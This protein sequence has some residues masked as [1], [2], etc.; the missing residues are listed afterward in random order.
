MLMGA[1]GVFVELRDTLNFIWNAPAKNNAGVWSV[2]RDR[3][4]SF[5]MVIAVGFLLAVSLALTAIAQAV[6]SYS[7]RYLSVA[8]SLAVISNFLVTIGVTSFL[9]AAIY[10]II[11]EVRVEWQDVAV[12]SV[13][14]ALL[15]SGGK[16]LIGL[17]LG[18]AGLAS[19]YGAAGS[20]VVLLV[21]VYYSAQIFLYGAEFTYVYARRRRSPNPA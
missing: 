12:G 15:F 21:W 19:T 18:R 7:G 2:I 11:P 10:R 17:Y 13:I 8:A 16:F 4:F 9:F 3:F 14:T 20:I 5:V 1:S 6:A